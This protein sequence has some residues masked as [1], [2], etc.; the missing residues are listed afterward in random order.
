MKHPV[1]TCLFLGAATVVVMAACV[2]LCLMRGAAARFHFVGA[3][4]LLAP[5]LALAAALT[6][7]GLS[8]AGLMAILIVAAL[9]LQGP[10]VAHV[11]ARAIHTYETQ[12]P[13]EAGKERP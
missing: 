6:E 7:E 13:R 8:Q 4:A 3:A 5:P 11:V 2:G 1:L 9:L 10:V 12:A